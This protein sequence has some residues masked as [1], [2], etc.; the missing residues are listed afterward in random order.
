L[1]DILWGRFGL[2][3][4]ESPHTLASFA[5]ELG[6]KGLVCH[7]VDV[8]DGVGIELVNEGLFIVGVLLDVGSQ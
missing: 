8:G 4:L 2:A 6:L 3:N 1:L 5:D 7:A